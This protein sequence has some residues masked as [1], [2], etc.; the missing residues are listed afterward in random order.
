MVFAD[1][2]VHLAMCG[3]GAFCQGHNFVQCTCAHSVAE[4]QAQESISQAETARD[5]G[6]EVFSAFGIHPQ[7]P[8]VENAAFLDSLLAQKKVCAIGECGFDFY[9]P[10]FRRNRLAQEQAWAVQLELSRRFGVPVV[11]HNR[12]A[13]DLMFRDAAVLKTLPAVVFHSFS[14]GPNEA[15]SLLSHGI[16]AFFS[17]GKPLLNGSRKARACVASLELSRLLLETDAPYQSLR[18]EARTEPEDIIAVYAEAASIRNMQPG[19]LA[20]A[21]ERTFRSVFTPRK[22]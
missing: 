2:H 14:F 17:F 6:L 7:S 5:G 3:R 1:A 8:L 10:D 13:L 16:N 21:L 18:C 12:K 11:V 9:T 4:W 15:R 19:L 20:G 22:D